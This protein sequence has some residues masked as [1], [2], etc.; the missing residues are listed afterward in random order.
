MLH[1]CGLITFII[2][3]CY[4]DVALLHLWS[5][6]V[7]FMEHYCIYGQRLLHL[8]G[9]ITFVVKYCYIYGVLLHLLS[10]V[11]TLMCPYYI[12]DEKFLHFK[13]LVLRPSTPIFDYLPW[14]I[15][16]SL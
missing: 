4:I 6:V 11:V 13:V 7:T 9:I 14:Q 16:H 3:I 1:L 8:W 10:K 15:T 12:Y 5:K 2:I